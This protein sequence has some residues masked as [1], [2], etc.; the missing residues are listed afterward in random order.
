MK[1]LRHCVL[2]FVSIFMFYTF[3]VIVFYA[4]C[5]TNRVLSYYMFPP[6]ALQRA[7]G[8]ILVIIKFGS[9]TTL[10]CK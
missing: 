10:F 2:H 4:L 8:K 7:V 9:Y 1:C 5:F 3:F 6:V